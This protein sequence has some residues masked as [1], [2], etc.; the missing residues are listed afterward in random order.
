ME[1]LSKEL[2]DYCKMWGIDVS[3]KVINKVAELCKEYGIITPPEEMY[4]HGMHELF[5]DGVFNEN[6]AKYKLEIGKKLGIFGNHLKEITWASHI[7]D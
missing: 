1:N 4:M 5:D 6:Y 2:I 3:A 7:G